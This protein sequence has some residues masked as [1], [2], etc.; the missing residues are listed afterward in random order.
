MSRTLTHQEAKRFYD[1][2]GTKQDAQRFYEDPAVEE[3]IRNGDFGSAQS[4]FEFG[5]GTGR[6]AERL[7]E[8]HLPPRAHYVA[9]DVSSTMV[10]VAE[11]RLARFGS[12]AQV[13]QTS[14]ETKF[15]VE[16]NR[17]DRFV[18]AYVLDLLSGE[19]TASLITEAHRILR[20]GG[21]A[22]LVSLTHGRTFLSRVVEKIW[23]AVHRL[24]PLL[25]GGCRPVELEGYLRKKGW[26][27]L[28]ID[29]VSSFGVTSEVVVAEKAGSF[30]A[31]EPAGR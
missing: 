7:L 24:N 8:R 18:S 13:V 29:R 25:V 2:F 14:G 23:V 22:V 3:L 15:D 4:V 9:V 12:R 28:H 1:W 11:R 26:S 17:F 5:C 21:L 30:A 27:I 6:L 19:D 31:V 20:P 16:D 10:R